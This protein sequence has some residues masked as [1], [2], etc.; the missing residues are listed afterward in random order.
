MASAKFGQSSLLRPRPFDFQQFLSHQ[1][2]TSSS[3]AMSAAEGEK[4]RQSGEISR[5]EPALPT[6]N[7][8]ADKQEPPKAAFH[9][10]V[11]VR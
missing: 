9:P 11:Y 10:A 6:V 2:R 1:P 7:P 5:P 3:F 8:A 4:A